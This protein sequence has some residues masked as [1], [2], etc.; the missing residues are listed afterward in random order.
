MC[1]VVATASSCPTHALSPKIGRHAASRERERELADAALIKLQEEAAAW[2]EERTKL[3]AQIGEE[4]KTLKGE[5][6]RLEKKTKEDALAWKREQA[7]LQGEILRLNEAI[8]TS[9]KDETNLRSELGAEREQR[10]RIAAEL[11]ELQGS[12]SGIESEKD[13][14]AVELSTACE[15]LE[16]LRLQH[17]ELLAQKS[18]ADGVSFFSL[19]FVV[20]CVGQ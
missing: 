1:D 12:R 7:R 15:A 17:K 20:C 19:S 18:A 2:Q 5:R 13:Q 6:A 16:G 9:H 8:A 10:N 11:A 4:A 14:I 3:E